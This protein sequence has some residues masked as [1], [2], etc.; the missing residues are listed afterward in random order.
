MQR[1]RQAHN[2]Y[3]GVKCPSC[4]LLK[5]RVVRTMPMEGYIRIRYHRCICGCRFKSVEEE[6]S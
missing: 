3:V 5:P 1:S 6:S 2:S 4:G